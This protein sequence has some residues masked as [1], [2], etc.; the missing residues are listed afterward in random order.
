MKYQITIRQ[1]EEYTPDEEKEVMGRNRYPLE[2]YPSDR[3]SDKN[4]HEIRVLQ[5]E[6]SKEEFEAVKKAIIGVL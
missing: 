4:F 6:V 2:T 1:L 3:F 5:A